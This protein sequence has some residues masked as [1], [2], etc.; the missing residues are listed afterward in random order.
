MT[1]TK[2]R[3][4][5]VSGSFVVV[6]FLLTCAAAAYLTVVHYQNQVISIPGAQLL[7]E[8]QVMATF[9]ES[10]APRI[11]EGMPAIVSIKG[12]ADQPFKGSVKLVHIEDSG[13]ATGIIQLASPPNNAQPP[14]D[15]KVTVDTTGAIVVK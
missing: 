8:G 15:C 11:R 6:F 3:T 13:E 12:Y 7:Y 10:I 9:E 14:L 2:K 1:D 5:S 4:N